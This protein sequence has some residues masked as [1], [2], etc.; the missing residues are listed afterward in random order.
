MKAF[1]FPFQKVFY[2][3]SEAVEIGKLAF[4]KLT[5][6][7]LLHLGCQN[8]ISFVFVLPRELTA[9]FAPSA[10]SQRAN[11]EPPGSPRFIALGDQDCLDLQC[12]GLAKTSHFPNVW[13]CDDSYYPGNSVIKGF[14]IIK[15]VPEGEI[16]SISL[17][18]R[19]LQLPR[20][21]LE[22]A[23]EI[24]SMDA[25]DKNNAIALINYHISSLQKNL[26]EYQSKKTITHQRETKKTTTPSII[27]TKDNP[28]EITINDWMTL[29][30][31][32]AEK[33]Y[34]RHN[35]EFNYTPPNIFYSTPLKKRGKTAEEF[36]L[37][38]ENAGF[39]GLTEAA[40]KYSFTQKELLTT[41]IKHESLIVTSIPSSLTMYPFESREIRF[42]V[43][44]RNA[45]RF[46]VVTRPMLETIRSN[47]IVNESTFEMA[48]TPSIGVS[49]LISENKVIDQD[50]KWRI[51]GND[52]K[53]QELSLTLGDLFTDEEKL[54]Q[55]LTEE[56]DKEIAFPKQSQPTTEQL[57]GRETESVLIQPPEGDIDSLLTMKETCEITNLTRTTIDNKGKKNH[58]G[59]DDSFPKKK[60][61]TPTPK[62][63][64]AYSK[65]AVLAWIKRQDTK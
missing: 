12:F 30:Q 28:L 45:P 14:W 13:I 43:H 47:D 4:P 25:L 57:V 56:S 31:I 58:A 54:S 11:Q 52:F 37:L 36:R 10:G 60:K 33:Y 24:L 32:S 40:T 23:M 35:G 29:D 5:A 19:N 46:A 50:W 8:T 44:K 6:N 51:V 59:Y 65:A 62:G 9:T 63:K 17:T 3:L 27:F 1:G 16:T 7:D 61:L 55:L 39:I 20:K 48:F 42:I 15:S 53:M 49:K 41:C 26:Y 38:L 22:R 2:S 18:H 21:Q 64:I 34:M